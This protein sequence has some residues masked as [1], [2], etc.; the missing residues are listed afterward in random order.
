M[1]IPGRGVPHMR[2]GGKGDLYVRIWIRLP[3]TLNQQQ[4]ELVEKLA[5][6]GL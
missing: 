1:R 3:K 6:T 2:G 5:E 4:R